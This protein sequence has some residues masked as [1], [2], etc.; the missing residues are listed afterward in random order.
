MDFLVL[1]GLTA[2]ITPIF[3]LFREILVK[4]IEYKLEKK[5]M[6]VKGIEL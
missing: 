3:M 6:S 4:Q 1:F 5:K 2:F